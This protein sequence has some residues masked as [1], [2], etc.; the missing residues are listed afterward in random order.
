LYF[1]DRYRKKNPTKSVITAA[2][3]QQQLFETC[4]LFRPNQHAVKCTFGGK[5]IIPEKF[6]ESW[7]ANVDC[8]LYLY[9]GPPNVKPHDVQM[10]EFSSQHYLWLDSMSKL[11]DH[12]TL[13]MPA[14]DLTKL[15]DANEVY[16]N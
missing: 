3:N 12:Y 2:F 11:Q 1:L 9:D 4:S 8:S 14:W 7:P 5:S 13:Y 6:T 10:I 15:Y 16:W